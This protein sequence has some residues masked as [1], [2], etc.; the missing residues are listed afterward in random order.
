MFNILAA[1]AAEMAYHTTRPPIAVTFP[2]P[3]VALLQR[4]W[5]ANPEVDSFMWSCWF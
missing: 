4:G 5:I 3:I 1:V 2:K